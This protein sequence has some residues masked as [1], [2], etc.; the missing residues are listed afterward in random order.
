MRETQSCP[1]S[2]EKNGDTM[3]VSCKDLID[4]Q[5]VKLK[6][7]CVGYIILLSKGVDELRRCKINRRSRWWRLEVM[8]LCC[9]RVICGFVMYYAYETSGSSLLKGFYQLHDNY[10]YTCTCIA[11]FVAQHQEALIT[12]TCTWYG[13]SGSSLLRVLPTQWWFYFWYIHIPLVSS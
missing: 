3:D 5:L 7:C 2:T 11:A 10:S 6:Y 1:K 8:S 12:C 9:S 4:C 13:T